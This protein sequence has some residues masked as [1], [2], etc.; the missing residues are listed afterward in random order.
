MLQGQC[1]CGA[2]PYRYGGDHTALAVGKKVRV[3]AVEPHAAT[4]I[5]RGFTVVWV[6]IRSSTE[7]AP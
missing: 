6:G 2:I 5:T 1:L 7:E 4:V 3:I